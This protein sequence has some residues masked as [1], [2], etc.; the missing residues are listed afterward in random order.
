M[1]IRIAADSKNTAV[2]L[3]R[4]FRFIKNPCNKIRLSLGLKILNLII[5]L[6]P[7]L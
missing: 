7:I 6:K 1:K 4:P 3:I 2:F 5:N